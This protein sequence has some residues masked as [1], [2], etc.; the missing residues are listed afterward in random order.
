MSRS[1]VDDVWRLCVIAVVDI[2]NPLLLISLALFVSV[3]YIV[4]LLTPVNIDIWTNLLIA[5]VITPAI[6]LTLRAGR[7][8]RNETTDIR[9]CVSWRVL[10]PLS[11]A[12]MVLALAFVFDAATIPFA[13]LN[14]IAHID[15]LFLLYHSRHIHGSHTA[16]KCHIAYPVYPAEPLLAVTLLWLL[17]LYE[18]SSIRRRVFRL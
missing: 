13:A 15:H 17:P 1:R 4:T 11:A 8:W 18:L 16:G 3:G 10:L 14:T 7:I 6:P 9:S 2:L 12:A 5:S